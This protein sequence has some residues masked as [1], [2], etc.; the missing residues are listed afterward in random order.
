VTRLLDPVGSTSWH[1]RHGESFRRLNE[2]LAAAPVRVFDIMVVGPGAVTRLLTPLL[3]DASRPTR[4]RWRKLVGDAARY[5]DQLLRRLPTMALRS[6]EPLELRTALSVPHRLVVVDRS[7]RVLAAVARDLPTARC[8]QADLEQCP[9]LDPAD[10][11]VAFN[12]ICRL[13]NPAAGLAAVAEA[14]RPG[15]WLLIDDRSA[16]HLAGRADFL[17]VGDKIHRRRGTSP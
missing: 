7:R 2:L 1:H 6:L 11:V 9:R 14:V 10:A 13:A 12:V 16:A 3:N 4:G 15:G 17:A 5:G 8:I